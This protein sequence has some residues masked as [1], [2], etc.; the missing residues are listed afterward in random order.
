MA[1]TGQAGD[2]GDGG[3]ATSAAITGHGICVDA[4]GT[5][6]VDSGNRVRKITLAGTIL[7]FAGTG[8]AGFSGEGGPALNA[9][10]ARPSALACDSKGNVYFAVDDNKSQP[11]R[12]C[13]VSPDGVISLV[14]GTGA[15]A[16]SGDG[17]PAT[18]ASLSNIMA[19][20]TDGPGNVYAAEGPPRHVVRK[21][22]IATGIISTIVGSGKV[23]NLNWPSGLF[24]TPAGALFIGDSDNQRILKIAGQ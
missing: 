4:A 19:L 9:E 21:I 15:E 10:I 12:I 1:G 18:Q 20:V 17:G 5:V 23:S 22:D 13:K 6:Y 11:T 8:V 2:T 3:P 16:S 24:L 14:A 7:P